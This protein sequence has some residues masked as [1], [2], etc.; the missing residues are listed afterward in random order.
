METTIQNG[1]ILCRTEHGHEDEIPIAAPMNT[2]TNEP[3]I[4][5]W[6]MYE[7]EEI[8][9]IDK[10]NGIPVHPSPTGS[11]Y[12]NSLTKIILYHLKFE[13]YRR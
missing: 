4:T 12:Y 8:L 7:D 10:P 1:D 5:T 2:E 13:V 9:V 3:D 6:M 11:F